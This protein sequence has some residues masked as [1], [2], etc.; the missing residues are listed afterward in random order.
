[1]NSKIIFYPLLAQVVLTFL[2]WFYMYYERLSELSRKKVKTQDLANP[3]LAEAAMSESVNSSDNLENLFEIPIL[4]Y[5][6]ILTMNALGDFDAGYFYL[7]CAFVFLRTLHSVIHCT[8][9]QIMHRFLAYVFSTFVL[10]I[11]WAR[12]VVHFCFK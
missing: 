11:I 12:I 6:A 5:I 1:M 3:A 8:Y 10:M 4:F 2:V 9:N 7:A